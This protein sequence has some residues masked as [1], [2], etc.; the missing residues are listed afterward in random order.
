M[1]QCVWKKDKEMKKMIDKDITLIIAFYFIQGVIHNLG[2][3]VTP[4]FVRGL[5]IPD[6]M[7]G[8]FFASMSF[9][10]MLGGPFWGVLSDRG[11]KKHLII[12]GL[13]FYSIGQFGF[14]YS[15]HQLAMVFFRF[16]SGF[17]VASSMTL[18]TSDLIE[19]SDPM[20]RA[21][22]LAYLAAAFTLGAS[23]GYAIGGFISTNPF[24]VSL[25]NITHYRKMF[26]IQAIINTVY[27]LSLLWL[28]KEAKAP[29]GF[30]KPSMIEGLKQLTK[31]DLSLFFFFLSLAMIT[32]GS[33]NLSK[34]IDVYFDQLGFSPQALGT[35]VMTTGIVSLITSIFLVPTFAR[36]KKQIGLIAVIHFLSA[37]IVFY[38]FRS[39]A[40][41]LSAYTIF[42]VY[43][44]FKTIYQPLEQNYIASYAKEGKYGS[45]MGLRQSFVSIGMVIGPLIGG[46]VYQQ[47]PL[48]LFD[49][50]AIFL[51]VGV[52]LLGFVYL[53]QKQEK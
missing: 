1:I 40:F 3:P 21:K 20:H 8:V 29:I 35:F 24:F 15:N 41:L 23:L 17:G 53:F 9:G 14:G 31:I 2:H 49:M 27:T 30:K 51:L 44:V 45:M 4:A 26:L 34:Y 46:F 36:A 32:M 43:V 7:F 39:T 22:H 12:I 38:V 18:L 10:L 16:L 52:L 19:K 42:M 50:S 37:L 48:W 28:L 6:Y 33:V 47:N 13:L 25:F 5:F 11:Q